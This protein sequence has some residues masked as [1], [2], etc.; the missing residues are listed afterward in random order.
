MSS[1]DDR[2]YIDS[3]VFIKQLLNK[4]HKLHSKCRKFFYDIENK[5]F[6]GITSSFTRSEY[7]ALVKEIIFKYAEASSTQKNIDI[8]MSVFDDFVD[9]MGIEYFNSDDLTGFGFK[10]FSESHERIQSAIPSRGKDSRWRT[11]GGADSIILVMA[12][13]SHANKIA[14][15]DDGFRKIDSKVKPL[16]VKD[17]YK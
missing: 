5:K 11:L 7:L 10:L 16:L 1:S 6:K 8:A 17:N 14:T 3:N 9:R 12:E 2:I 4:E 15:N 13:R